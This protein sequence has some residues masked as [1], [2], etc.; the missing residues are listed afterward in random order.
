MSILSD[1]S[2]YKRRIIDKSIELYLEIC[3]AICIEGPK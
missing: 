1:K 3:G 2:K